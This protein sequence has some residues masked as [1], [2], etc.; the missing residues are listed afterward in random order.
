M[1]QILENDMLLIEIDDKGAELSRIYDK[2]KDREV[3]WDADP[4]YWGR[5]APVLFPNVGRHCG[6]TYRTGGKS[7]PSSQH[8]FARDLPF[9]CV[10][11]TAGSLT[12]Q[13][14]SDEKTLSSY[15]FPFVLRVRHALEGRKLTIFWEVRNPGKDTMYF[16]I[17]G[18]PAFALPKEQ[19]EQ[20]R[21]YFEG[22]DQLQ[23]LLITPDGS[24]TADAANI[25]TV[26]LNEGYVC[27]DRL[28]DGS[29]V[30]AEHFFDK[31]ALIFDNGQ[32]E[33][34]KIVLPD[35]SDYLEMNSPG[36][37]HFGIWAAPLAPFVCLEPWAGRTDDTGFTGEL[38]EKPAINRLDP[39]EIFRKSYSIT[40]F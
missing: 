23:Y 28:K 39:A 12:H 18:H 15:P 33:K 35:G 27:L 25:H 8:G 30:L 22:K 9:T 1:R 16:A 19:Y 13:L 40:V 10:E 32:I 7:Y 2:E 4:E 14:L 6:N 38:S 31:D 3:L 34:V 11:K 29:E 26:Q 37:P 5:H 36:F 17:G 20:C 24:G 21:L